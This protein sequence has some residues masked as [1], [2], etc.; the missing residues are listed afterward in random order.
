MAVHAEL[1]HSFFRGWLGAHVKQ[2][3]KLPEPLHIP[4]PWDTQKEA[5]RRGTT[6]T[7]L[8]ALIKDHSA[9]TRGA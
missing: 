3:T 5:R 1:L 9:T 4:R 6:M 7:E 2:G 8:R